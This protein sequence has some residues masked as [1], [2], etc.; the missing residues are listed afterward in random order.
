MIHMDLMKMEQITEWQVCM[1]FLALKIIK[2]EKFIKI[3]I[4]LQFNE[5]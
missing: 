4:V 1:K 3:K 5:L 2:G